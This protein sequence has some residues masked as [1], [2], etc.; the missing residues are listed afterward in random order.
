MENET[1]KEVQDVKEDTTP[2]S[3][4]KQIVNSV[5]Y[6]RFN[7]LVAEKNELKTQLD[8]I[9]K[10]MKADTE[11]TKLKQMEVKRKETHVLE[12]ITNRIYH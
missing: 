12:T 10:Q 5:P 8:S 4:E 9:N 3:E 2:A 1:V 7:E 6:A 11:A